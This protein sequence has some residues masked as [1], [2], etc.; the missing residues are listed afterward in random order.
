MKKYPPIGCV[1]VL[2]VVMGFTLYSISLPSPPEP[3]KN[4]LAWL[5]QRYGVS[6]DKVRSVANAL[7]VK[8]ED[9]ASFG[10]GDFPA[11]FIREKLRDIEAHSGR[12][13]KEDVDR[14]VQGYEAKCGHSGLVV[15]YL[16]YSTNL[17]SGVFR[18]SNGEALVIRFVYKRSDQTIDNWGVRDIHDS[19]FESERLEIRGLCAWS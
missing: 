11:N 2:F 4:S 1:I 8:P 9:M 3:P 10:G 13:T 18:S 6:E 16:F 14:L 15:Y 12:V 19:G 5:A 17:D 7:N